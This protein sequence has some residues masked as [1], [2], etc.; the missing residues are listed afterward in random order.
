MDDVKDIVT[1]GDL[2]LDTNNANAGTTRGSELLRESIDAC[3]LGRSI[4]VDKHGVVIAGNKTLEAAVK[5]G[6]E[7]EVIQT[8]GHELVVVQRTDLDLVE[9]PAARRLA[10]Y[11]NRVQ[12]LDLSWSP[13]QIN[14]D[15]LAGVRV[16][17]A[18]FPEEID[19]LMKGVRLGPTAQP[20]TEEAAAAFVPAESAQSYIIIFDTP[21]QKLVWAHFM[22]RL[23]VKYP[24]EEVRG[25][26][27]ARYLSDLGFQGQQE[28]Y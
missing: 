23:R 20:S 10:Y 4:L 22:R 2:S 15:M 28:E 27:I 11:D 8:D 1:V 12:E 24:D 3:G 13:R 21:E 7:L 18:F 25:G 19:E 17:E 6:A 16:T 9:D 14:D 26:G 5:M